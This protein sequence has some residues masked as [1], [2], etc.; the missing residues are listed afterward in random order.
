MII[1]EKE[2][3]FIARNEKHTYGGRVLIEVK[4][5]SALIEKIDT[6]LVAKVGYEDWIA[7]VREGIEFALATINMPSISIQ[8]TRILG[9]DMDTNP[10]ILAAAGADA[11]WRSLNFTPTDT[12]RKFIELVAFDSWSR[13]YKFVPN[14]RSI[15]GNPLPTPF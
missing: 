1:E 11:V 14:L 3:R 5:N 7:G 15:E 9:Q 2:G 10:S 8:V 12:Q 13:D 4:I 6:A